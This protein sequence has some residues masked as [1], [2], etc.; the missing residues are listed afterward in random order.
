MSVKMFQVFPCSPISG[1]LLLKLIS[2]KKQLLARFI[3][4]V[5]FLHVNSIAGRVILACCFI[6][7]MGNMYNYNPSLPKVYFTGEKHA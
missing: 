2:G 6:Y 7:K 3:P 1:E 5:I 4:G